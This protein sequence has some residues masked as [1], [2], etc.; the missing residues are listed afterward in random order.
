M[1]DTYPTTP[2]PTAMQEE[3]RE[4]D[5]VRDEHEGGYPHSRSR[6]NVPLRRVRLIYEELALSDFEAL[7]I[8][9]LTQR[10]GEQR[11]RYDYS[12]DPAQ[13]FFARFTSDRLEWQ[14]SKK[15]Y[16]TV[17]EIEEIP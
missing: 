4:W 9:W 17:V 2:K 10:G 1:P 14:P 3:K 13:G 15:G 16:T 5:T 8:F 12:V 7:Y 6:Y 11:F